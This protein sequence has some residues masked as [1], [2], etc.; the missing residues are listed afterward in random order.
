MNHK[1]HKS[2]FSP[3]TAN[4]ILTII[5]AGGYVETAAGH[6]GISKVTVYNWLKRGRAKDCK[7]AALAQF[8]ADYDATIAKAEL[9][10]LQKIQ[11]ASHDT[12]TAAAWILERRFPDRW[13][14][15]RIELT[16]A[17]GNSINVNGKVTI[18]MP[19]NGRGDAK[20]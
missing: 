16:G 10:L 2:K 6:A 12:W 8:A 20:D 5:S 17:D 13:G 19:D 1:H 15:K 9:L 18:Y 7:D 14:R 3:E 4:I 11:A